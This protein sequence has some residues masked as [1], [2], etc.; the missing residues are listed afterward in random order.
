MNGATV[1]ATMS[2]LILVFIVILLLWSADRSAGKDFV[3]IRTGYFMMGDHEKDPLDFAIPVHKVHVKAFYLA[4]YEVTVAEFRQFVEATGYITDAER[5]RRGG[6]VDGCLP[7]RPETNWRNPGFTQTDRHPVV[8]VSTS[9]A[10]AYILWL[11][12]KTGKR[13]RLPTEAEWEYAARAGSTAKYSFGRRGADWCLHVNAA[14]QSYKNAF[15]NE[16]YGYACDDGHAYTAPVGSYPANKWGLHDMYGNVWE[17]TGD[18]WHDSYK[19][20]PADGSA[21]L[22]DDCDTGVIRGSGWDGNPFNLQ[23]GFRLFRSY[24][25]GGGDSVGFRLV[26]EQ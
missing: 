2:L 4:R 12:K 26:L 10:R 1:K 17:M 8:C 20:A 18:C 11:N 14:D 23:A 7:G 25:S 15:P 19:G 3:S 16:K 9:D 13:Y 24:T 6:G 21:W 22:E 5:E